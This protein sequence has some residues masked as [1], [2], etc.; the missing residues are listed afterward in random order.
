[1]LTGD[2]PSESSTFEQNHSSNP[3]KLT[4]VESVRNETQTDIVQAADVVQETTSLSNS[5]K[6]RTL[7]TPR[8]LRPRPTWS[9]AFI[10]G[11]QLSCILIFWSLGVACLTSIPWIV[12]KYAQSSLQVDITQKELAVSVTEICRRRSNFLARI[13]C[14]DLE[15]GNLIVAFPIIMFPAVVFVFIIR[16][17]K[18]QTLGILLLQYASYVLLMGIY[19]SPDEEKANY[20]S[21]LSQVS[22]TIPTIYIALVLP[23]GTKLWK[24]SVQ[25][26]LICAL[27][28]FLM[29]LHDAMIKNGLQ[30]IVFL[31]IVWPMIREFFY[32]ISR[33]TAQHV[34][35]NPNCGHNK[36]ELRR[37]YAWSIVLFV[38]IFLGTWYRLMS[39]SIQ[40]D[41][42]YIIFVIFSSAQ[43]VGFRLSL[44]HRYAFLR[45]CY[46]CFAPGM[47]AQ[48][49]HASWRRSSLVAPISN[50]RISQTMHERSHQLARSEW[51]VML[52][53][54]EMISEYISLWTTFF[55]IIMFYGDIFN[56]PLP[57][58]A[59]VDSSFQQTSTLMQQLLKCL[60]QV[61]SEIIVDTLCMMYEQR[62][63]NYPLHV[64]WACIPRLTRL[65][66]FIIATIP[67]VSLSMTLFF[68]AESG[69]IGT[70]WCTS[71][72]ICSCLPPKTS[73]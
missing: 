55:F 4:G 69:S 61:A 30:E 44:E 16:L 1:M 10:L 29:E 67:A 3:L 18:I 53:L 2:A 35:M 31:C 49:A 19:L 64:I 73:K 59:S 20:E 27:C 48:M 5:G 62:V 65:T 26:I 40:K 39:T 46:A 8:W 21:I 23:K 70:E 43:E 12:Y 50:R 54:G 45:K 15:F 9:K 72:Y 32:I 7:V 6:R 66:N 41:S 63:R 33:L 42:N 14:H 71:V 25:F 28:L 13:I 36:V 60:G 56:L 47:A 57:I 58:F 37:H 38:Q 17:S 52:S 68:S 22:F 51:F 11:I 24:T 34:A